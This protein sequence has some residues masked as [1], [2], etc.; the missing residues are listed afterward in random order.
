MSSQKRALKDFSQD[1]LE[2]L[3]R[4]F[5]TNYLDLLRLLGKSDQTL[6]SSCSADVNI[7]FQVISTHKEAKTK[8][9]SGYR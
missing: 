4:D 6:M 3:T 5:F 1:N 8:A 7:E 2:V 9:W